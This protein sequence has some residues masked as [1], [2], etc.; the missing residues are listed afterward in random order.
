MAG[1]ARPGHPTA[2]RSD[3]SKIRSKNGSEFIAERV[4]DCITA[5][6]ARTAVNGAGL[7]LGEW[8]CES[9]DVRLRDELLNGDSL[10]A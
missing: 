4:R 9:F 1:R 3:L 2:L 6:G 10:H 8:L 5:V 7:A